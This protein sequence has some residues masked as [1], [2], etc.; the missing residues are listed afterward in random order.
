MERIF[1][2]AVKALLLAFGIVAVT[3]VQTDCCRWINL[4]SVPVKPIVAWWMLIAAVTTALREIRRGYY[5]LAVAIFELAMCIAGILGVVGGLTLFFF[6]DSP[7][8]P[9][10]G[11]MLG[12]TLFWSVH[13]LLQ[14]ERIK[15]VKALYFLVVAVGAVGL[16]G[17]ILDYPLL[18]YEF[19]GATNA[20]ALSSA[21]FLILL[22]LVAYS[23]ERQGP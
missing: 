20:M 12:F 5:P 17:H 6:T 16:L 18:R 22:G 9:S 11:T 21:F 4:A 10:V 7:S 2:F 1:R 3:H 19:D 13:I 8:V 14:I 23:R 15:H